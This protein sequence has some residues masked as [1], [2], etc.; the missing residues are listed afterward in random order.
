MNSL[1]E[2]SGHWKRMCPRRK[3]V[4]VRPRIKAHLPTDHPQDEAIFVHGVI[5]WPRPIAGLVPYVEEAL[6]RLSSEKGG[7]D[8]RHRGITAQ[9]PCKG[10]DLEALHGQV[11]RQW[12]WSPHRVLSRAEPL[13]S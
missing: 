1:M 8:R 9:C 2:R 4:L 6:A 12:V 11:E 10:V 3:P 13:L 7:V 5:R